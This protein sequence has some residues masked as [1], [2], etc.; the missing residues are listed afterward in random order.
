MALF[1]FLFITSSYDDTVA[2]Y[3]ETMGLSI[4]DS[5]ADPERGTLIATAGDAQLE[6]LEGDAPELTGG[7][8]IAWEVDDIDAAY[9]DLLANGVPFYGPP[10]DQPWGHRNARLQAP[11]GLDITLFTV[12]GAES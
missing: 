7:V 1:R 10:V 8:A 2:F 3:A 5:W 12:P 11:G 6:I 4:V 9:A